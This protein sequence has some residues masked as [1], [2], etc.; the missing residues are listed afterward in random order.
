MQRLPVLAVEQ[1]DPRQ[2]IASLNVPTAQQA[3]FEADTIRVRGEIAFQLLGDELRVDA[4]VGPRAVPE[5]L[6][7][8]STQLDH[9]VRDLLQG[10]RWRVG[11]LEVPP[12]RRAGVSHGYELASS[13]R[14]VRAFWSAGEAGWTGVKYGP[15]IVEALGSL[16]SQRSALPATR[17]DQM[18]GSTSSTRSLGFD[19]RAADRP[20]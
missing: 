18:K 8:L 6:L 5:L 17:H 7:E 12:C 11:R 2:R 13:A 1:R 3:T 10:P 15:L 9:R 4:A 19:R 16:R 14:P 20:A